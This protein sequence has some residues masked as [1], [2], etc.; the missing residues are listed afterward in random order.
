MFGLP[1]LQKFISLPE[2][3][4]SE[5]GLLTDTLV[6]GVVLVAVTILAL[7]ILVR[8]LRPSRR[9]PDRKR[10][11]PRGQRPATPPVPRAKDKRP[12]VLIDGSNV[13]HWLD[14]TPQLAPV[15]EV[16]R[17]LSSRGM[18]PGVV[19][20]AN[21]GYKLMGKFLGEQE[22]AKL[23]SLPKD[24]ILVVPKGTQADPYLLETARD[25]QARIVTN[26]RYR[27]WAERYPDVAKPE[28]LVQGEMR[29]GRVWLKGMDK[30]TPSP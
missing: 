30:S 3:E 11:R 14:N 28:N 12:V 8:A 26:D 15:R 9:R 2:S 24:Q 20:D 18:K 21:A 29:D 6:I 1:L 17:D 25:L 4:A 16:V 19:F 10:R 7:S 27:D 5:P 13:M 23:L 22:L